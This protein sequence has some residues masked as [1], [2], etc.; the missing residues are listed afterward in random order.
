MRVR[1]RLF[2]SLKEYYGP[3]LVLELPEASCAGDVLKKMADI[4]P[5]GSRLLSVCKLA[6]DESFAEAAH[7]LKNGDEVYV[8]P[9]FSGG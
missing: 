9:P 8:L 3:E 6:V 1:V 4:N 5:E 2:A 7:P